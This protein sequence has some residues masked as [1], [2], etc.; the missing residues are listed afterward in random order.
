MIKNEENLKICSKC[1][2]K[3]PATAKYFH[4][5]KNRNDGLD[6][7]CKECKKKYHKNTYILRK[8]KLSKQNFKKLLVEQRSRCAICGLK[9]DEVFS[10]YN[11][12]Q[13]DYNPDIDHSHK[14]GKV[15][16]L[17]CLNCNRSLGR[18]KENPLIL[19]RAI[20]YLNRHKGK[21]N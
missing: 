11:Y 15:R 7:W 2:V 4:R 19:L 17:L 1:E 3:Y 6:S 13:Y 14:T 10:I 8:Y 16:G 5:H 20:K 12:P 9:F 21:M 18:C